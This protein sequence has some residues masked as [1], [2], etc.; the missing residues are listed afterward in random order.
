MRL[1]T[2]ERKAATKLRA[3]EGDYYFSDSILNNYFPIPLL[4]SLTLPSWGK[5]IS[6]HFRRWNVKPKAV[7]FTVL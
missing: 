5:R 4:I 7:H 3:A 6:F 1:I 2:E